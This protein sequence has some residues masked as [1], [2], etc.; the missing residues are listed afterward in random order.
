MPLAVAGAVAL[1]GIAGMMV[2]WVQMPGK[3]GAV[4][5]TA[6]RFREMRTPRS[7]SGPTC[8][9]PSTGP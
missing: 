1:A 5:V 2:I 4:T 6:G 8:R 9:R 7:I 3:P